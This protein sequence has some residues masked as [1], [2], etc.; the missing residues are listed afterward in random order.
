MSDH[1]APPNTPPTVTIGGVEVPAPFQARWQELIGKNQAL[2]AQ[3]LEA[4]AASTDGGPAL[5]AAQARIQELEGKVSRAEHSRLLA[6]DGVD[7]DDDLY[8][9]LQFQYGKLPAPAEGEERP[10]FGT[11]YAEAKTTN[12]VLQ[13]ALQTSGKPA[14]TTPTTAVKPAAPKPVPPKVAPERKPAST[15]NTFSAETIGGLDMATWKANKEAIRKS[16]F[17][18]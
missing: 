13:A 16:L 15:D 10:D 11:W 7:G 2:K 8:E 3:L 6:A 17:G 14:A 18:S 4:Q 12:R 1:E 5:Q 9:Y